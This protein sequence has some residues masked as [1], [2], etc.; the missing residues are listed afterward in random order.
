M[1]H[2]GKTASALVVAAAFSG[3]FIGNVAAQT[4]AVPQTRA[5][6]QA[7]FARL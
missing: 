2:R 1:S 7:S 4:R 5:D 6:V 3:L